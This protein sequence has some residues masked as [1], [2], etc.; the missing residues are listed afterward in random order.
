[1]PALIPRH[2]PLFALLASACLGCGHS[3]RE[4]HRDTLANVD[5]RY[6]EQHGQIRF[7]NNVE[8]G[9]NVAA[10]HGMPCLFFFTAEWCTYCHRMA[11]TAFADKRVGQLGVNFV[12]VIVDADRERELCSYFSVTGFPTVE[13]VSPHGQSLHRLVGQQSPADLAAGM[14][15]ALGRYAWL[16]NSRMR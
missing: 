15:A 4:Q 13:F 1:M 9:C 14:Q 8:V 6:I 12:C 2:L 5:S 16:D 11:E 10:E 7:V 3:N